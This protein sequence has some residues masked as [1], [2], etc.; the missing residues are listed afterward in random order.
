[1]KKFTNLEQIDLGLTT[2]NSELVFLTENKEQRGSLVLVFEDNVAKVFSLHVLLESRGK[3][4]GKK[5]MIKAIER[6]IEKRCVCL[7]LN[8]ETD[9]TAANKLYESLGFKLKGINFG[10]NNWILN[11]PS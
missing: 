6:C 4:Y 8:T 5:L 1:M 9:N 3:G 11:L 7:E 2:L 10:F